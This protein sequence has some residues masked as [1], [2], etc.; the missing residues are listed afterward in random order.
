MYKASLRGVDRITT[1]HNCDGVGMV[2]G[3]YR[4]GRC[5]YC[6]GEGVRRGIFRRVD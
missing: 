5:Y 1:C 3:G 4:K 6:N 2:E